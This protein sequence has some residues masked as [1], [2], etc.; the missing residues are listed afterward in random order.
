MKL[1]QPG[2]RDKENDVPYLEQK[3]IQNQGYNDRNIRLLS[4]RKKR[5]PRMFSCRKS[6]KKFLPKDYVNKKK[7]HKSAKLGNQNFVNQQ[8]P[9][10]I[11]LYQWMNKQEL[12]IKTVK[13][14]NLK[15]LFDLL[16]M[17]IK[18]II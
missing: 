4:P 3:F 15:L 5:R 2:Q 18:Y 10:A 6:T 8:D 13:M 12:H 11:E 17:L 1:D 16:K 14:K 7:R 9:P